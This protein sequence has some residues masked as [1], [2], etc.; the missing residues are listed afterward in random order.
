GTFSLASPSGQGSGVADEA[1]ISQANSIGNP[2]S[3]TFTI[4]RTGATTGPLT[5][6]FTLSGTA[7]NGSTYTASS[8]SSVVIPINA[9]SVQVTITPKSTITD[10]TTLTV[11]LT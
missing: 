5:V 4:T 3:G 1:L 2:L 9:S 6:L 11:V 10:A 7:T 8:V